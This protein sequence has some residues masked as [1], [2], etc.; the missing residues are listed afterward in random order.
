MG[1]PARC[2]ARLAS[3]CEVEASFGTT[4]LYHK[5]SV[6]E[7]FFLQAKASYKAKS[8]DWRFVRAARAVLKVSIGWRPPRRSNI[9]HKA[10]PKAKKKARG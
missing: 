2:T 10:R 9:K 6:K 4:R 7:K 5:V 3:F 8:S 1:G